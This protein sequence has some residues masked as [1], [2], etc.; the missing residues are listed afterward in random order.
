[1]VTMRDILNDVSC[2]VQAA[3]VI[4]DL[5]DIILMVGKLAAD[6]VLE[7][8]HHWLKCLKV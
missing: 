6:D 5:N 7:S 1:M 4:N 8:F 2:P 3:L